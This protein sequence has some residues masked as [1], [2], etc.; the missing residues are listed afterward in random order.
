MVLF[1]LAAWQATKPGRPARNHRETLALWQLACGGTCLLLVLAAYLV[2]AY[3]PTYLPKPHMHLG[4][5]GHWTVVSSGFALGVVVA[6]VGYIAAWRAA[7]R[8]R[9]TPGRLAVVFGVAALGSALLLPAYPLLSDDIFYSI[10]GGRIIAHYGQ[11]PFLFPPMH[12]ASDPFLPYAGWKDLTMPYGPLWALL[13]GG[14]SKLAGDSLLA[15]VLAFKG[16][17]VVAFLASA[18]LIAVLLR[19]LR[20]ERMLAGTLLWAWNPLV[21]VESAGHGHNGGVM[22]VLILLALV[23]VVYR[24]PAWA[25][26]VLALAA[27]IKFAALVLLPLA[28]VY[29][30]RHYPTWPTRLRALV[31]AGLVTVL[32][33]IM[34]YA[35]FWVGPRTI[36]LVGE[37]HYTYGSLTA[38]VRRLLHERDTSTELRNINLVKALLC[39]CAYLWLLREAWQGATRFLRACYTMMLLT[40]MLWPFFMPWYALWVTALAALRGARNA[41]RHVIAFSCA[42]ALSY[43]GQYGLRDGYHLPIHDWSVASAIFVFGALFA[44]IAWPALYH[45]PV[46]LMSRVPVVSS[47]GVSREKV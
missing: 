40:L 12:F 35:P 11:N 19:R 46:W 22:V 25:L 32:I 24:R 14:V 10:F 20:P 34:L 27:M 45:A 13:S 2:V 15:N 26:P 18:A 28:A 23:C 38:I 21:L 8:L 16:V 37:S 44:A 33:P 47:E 42:A 30:I 39:L 7:R 6:F 4:R 43:L 5:L 1:A 36:G 17:E 31:P 9:P 3:L 41:P 29:A